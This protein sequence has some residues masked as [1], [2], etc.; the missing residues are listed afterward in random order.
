MANTNVIIRVELRGEPSGSIY[1]QLHKLM[2][3]DLK[4]SNTIVADDGS[5]MP[6]PSATY[7]GGT[8]MAILELS[9]VLKSRIIKDIWQH[10][11]RVLVIAWSGW[12][13]ATTSPW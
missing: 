4:W 9:S 12:A 10:G 1:S 8:D 6:L 5:I 3:G 2:N 13:E 7:C 11:A